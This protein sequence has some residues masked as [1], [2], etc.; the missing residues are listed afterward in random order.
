MRNSLM[1]NGMLSILCL[2]LCLCMTGIAS[3]GGKAKVVVNDQ[4]V[5]K[6]EEVGALV[7][8]D[9]DGSY[10]VY[11][12]LT[13]GV[14]GEQLMIFQ[15]DGGMVPFNGDFASLP[16]LR[17]NLNLGSLSVEDKIITLIPKVPLVDTSSLRGTYTFIVALCTPGQLDFPVF[18]QLSVE[19]K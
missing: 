19:I 10:D 14:F 18:D 13:G 16:R 11:A 3:A 5:E 17:T 6:G 9:G 8:L 7:I 15:E 4:M 1:K 2:C 12:A